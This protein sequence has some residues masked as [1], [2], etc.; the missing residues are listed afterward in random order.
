MQE[1]GV[2]NYTPYTVL[3]A[4][5]LKRLVN[6]PLYKKRKSSL[7]HIPS[8]VLSNDNNGTFANATTKVNKTLSINSIGSSNNEFGTSRKENT[9]AQIPRGD[10]DMI[11]IEV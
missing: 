10:S 3:P 9:P 6:N 1:K 2:Y 11:K 4:P 7:A 8:D 5:K